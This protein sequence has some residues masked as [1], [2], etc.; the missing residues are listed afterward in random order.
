MTENASF[1]LGLGTPGSAPNGLWG[2]LFHKV[3][4]V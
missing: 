3:D 2:R 4:P 1:P